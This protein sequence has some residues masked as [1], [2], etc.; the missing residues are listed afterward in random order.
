MVS[1]RSS[2]MLVVAALAFTTALVAASPVPNL[3]LPDLKLPDLSAFGTK[4][5]LGLS[6]GANGGWNFAKGA[7]SFAGSQLA[8]LSADA[9]ASAAADSKPG[10]VGGS[11]GGVVLRAMFNDWASTHG[12][13]YGTAGDRQGAFQ[14]FAANMMMVKN[15]N[16]DPSS[17]FYA[18]GNYFAVDWTFQ[19]Y[20]GGIYAAKTCNVYAINHAMVAVGYV[21]NATKAAENHW[22]I[23]NSWGTSWG[24]GGYVRVRMPGVVSGPGP[25]GMYGT[26]FM[27]S[28]SFVKTLA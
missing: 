12:Q 9:I 2:C 25:C 17:T 10:G 7:A 6:A 4:D 11:M 1:A 3:N 23:R 14:N 27:P 16:S 20:G 19:V 15:I 5:L 26:A 13:A 21:A 8:A 18:S 22:K 28:Q 24:E